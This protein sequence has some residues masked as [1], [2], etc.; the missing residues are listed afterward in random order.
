LRRVWIYLIATASVQVE[1]PS[2]LGLT[3]NSM[4]IVTLAPFYYLKTAHALFLREKGNY[5]LQL[6]SHQQPF[7]KNSQG[8]GLYFLPAIIANNLS[9]G[10]HCACIPIF[11]AYKFFFLSFFLL[12]RRSL[13]P[14]SSLCIECMFKTMTIDLL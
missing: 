9:K 12:K 6:S 2:H 8:I 5:L 13:S 1:E 11:S 3:P 7:P 14:L 4:I 10:D